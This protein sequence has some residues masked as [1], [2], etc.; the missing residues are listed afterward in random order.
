LCFG[1]IDVSRALSLPL[2]KHSVNPKESRKRFTPIISGDGVEII[3]QMKNF[4][5]KHKK[6]LAFVFFEE[7]IRAGSGL[8]ASP[9]SLFL[10]E[11]R[12]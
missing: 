1:F 11:K 4:Y 2:Q 12:G 8:R 10:R 9:L 5:P 7:Y 3:R 6:S